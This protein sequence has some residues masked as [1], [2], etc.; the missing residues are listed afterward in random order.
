MQFL[1]SVFQD[2]D[3]PFDK[4]AWLRHDVPPILHCQFPRAEEVDRYTKTAMIRLPRLIRLVRRLRYD[5]YSYYLRDEAAVLALELSVP[6]LD[7]WL[8]ECRA[9]GLIQPSISPLPGSARATSDNLR[10]PLLSSDPAITFSTC[11]LYMRFQQYHSVR[12]IVSGCVQS[13]LRTCPEISAQ[14]PSL[15]AVTAA[16]ADIDSALQLAACSDYTAQDPSSMQLRQLHY[17]WPLIFSF[18]TW[19]RLEH[20][21]HP[22]LLA[23]DEFVGCDDYFS[24]PSR[25]SATSVSM[26][27]A[28]KDWIV[29]RVVGAQVA[30]SSNELDV[31]VMSGVIDWRFPNTTRWNEDGMS[32]LSEVL[33]GGK[34]GP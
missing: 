4:P 22:P 8:A 23:S 13:L 9:K 15:N 6:N 18:G 21:G 29:K 30:G 16:N 3:S 20:S 2:R 7:N 24:I 33:A 12:I 14:H 11:R 25:S 28:M 26:A 10:P 32:W 19:H 34:L 31:N 17:K 1:V 5:P 27:R